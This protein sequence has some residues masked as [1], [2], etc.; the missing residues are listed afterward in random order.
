MDL[1]QNRSGRFPE[2][3][4]EENYETAEEAKRLASM[5][6]VKVRRLEA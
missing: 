3:K 2:G 1:G 6:Q 4:N 5:F